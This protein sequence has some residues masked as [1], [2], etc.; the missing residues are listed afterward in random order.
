MQWVDRLDEAG[1]D[2]AGM[3]DRGMKSAGRGPIIERGSPRPD[4]EKPGREQQPAPHEQL[5][6]QTALIG[7]EKTQG[8]EWKGGEER[9]ASGLAKS[10]GTILPA[11]RKL[12][13]SGNIPPILASRTRSRRVHTGVRTTGVMV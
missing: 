5:E 9:P 13:I 3:G 1:S 2:D 6:T 12:T 4:D 7:N 8:Q 10:D 11:L